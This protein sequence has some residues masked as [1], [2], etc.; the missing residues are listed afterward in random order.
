MKCSCPRK[1]TRCNSPCYRGIYEMLPSTSLITCMSRWLSYPG[2]LCDDMWVALVTVR[3]FIQRFFACTRAHTHI[4][5]RAHT[6]THARARAHT[7]TQ[8][9][10]ADWP[11]ASY[12]STFHDAFPAIFHLLR[13]LT[14]HK[15]QFLS[16]SA[17][18]IPDDIFLFLLKHYNF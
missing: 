4:H 6:H 7:H 9:I 1:G 11:T 17:V 13:S 8:K 10:V 16:L 2:R 12:H 15:R 18:R 14:K 5:T 3:V